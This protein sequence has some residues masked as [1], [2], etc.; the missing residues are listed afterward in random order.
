MEGA[1]ET[2]GDYQLLDMFARGG[3]GELFRARQRGVD[4]FERHL[5]VKRISAEHVGKWP[6]EEMFV[7]E[8]RITAQLSHP[9]I[10]Q[11]HA[12]GRV[13]GVP[14]M[15]MELVEGPDLGVTITRARER[16]IEIPLSFALSVVAGLAAALSHAHDRR[17][18]DGTPMELVHRDV[19][20]HNVVLSYEGA[21]KLVDFGL[22]RA[23][24]GG[25]LLTP[26]GKF[27]GNEAYRAPEQ[28]V[29][30]MVDRRADVFSLGTI[31]YELLAGVPCFIGETPAEV[32][33]QV[34]TREPDFAAL[35]ARRR[36]PD[37]FVRVL[38]RSLR[39][40]RHERYDSAASMERD[41]E[42]AAQACGIFVGSGPCA[43]YLK[44]LADPPL[45]GSEAKA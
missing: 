28:L 32:A 37:A 4:D 6:F 26:P 11:I 5:C 17:A 25:R 36:L 31:L 3:M 9:N 15:A 24:L 1:P 22:A 16:G 19:S 29:D 20:P 40:A 45:P 30:P 23:M 2:F 38:D 27:D 12:Y 13:A 43:R 44:T 21:V 39:K 34:T 33:E 14:Y 42:A 7:A 41:L 8:A 10:P 35:A 18:A